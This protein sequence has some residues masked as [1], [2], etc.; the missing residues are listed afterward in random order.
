MF[1]QN[2]LKIIKKLNSPKK[3]Q[4]FLN[5]L[6]I[7]FEENGETCMSPRK[8]LKERKA[9]CI[10]GAILAAAILKNQGFKPLIVDLEANNNDFDHVIAVFKIKKHW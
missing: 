1:N 4:D 7:N 2:E 3:I 8:V 5:N 6:K 10:E 9:H